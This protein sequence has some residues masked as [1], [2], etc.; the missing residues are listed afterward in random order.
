MEHYDVALRALFR[1]YDRNTGALHEQALGQ[2]MVD[3][4]NGDARLHPVDEEVQIFIDAMDKDGD[5]SID[6]NECKNDVFIFY[7]C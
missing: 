2:L 5:H 7:F 1:N 3:F 6:E 4:A